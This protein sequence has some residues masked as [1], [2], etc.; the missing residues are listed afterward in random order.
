MKL[1]NDDDITYIP[2]LEQA[3]IKQRSISFKHSIAI[4]GYVPEEIKPLLPN[5]Q[6]TNPLE[7]DDSEE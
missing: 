4:Q 6:K 2:G 7:L 3:I 5:D 1:K